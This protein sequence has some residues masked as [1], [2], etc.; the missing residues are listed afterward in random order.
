MREDVLANELG[1]LLDDY[2]HQIEGLVSDELEDVVIVLD[3]RLADV[4]VAITHKRV[5]IAVRVCAQ[6]GLDVE[7]DV[8]DDGLQ[9]RVLGKNPAVLFLVG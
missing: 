7:V 5:E 6:L 4:D 3:L 9:I 2:E 1:G 8:L